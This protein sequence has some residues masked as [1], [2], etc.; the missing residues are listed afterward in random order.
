MRTLDGATETLRHTFAA[1][2]SVPSGS[3]VVVFGGGTEAF[4]PADPAFGCAQVVKASSGRL[5][6]L[7]SG[8]TIVVTDANGNLTA[9]LTYG[10]AGLNGGA[11]QS[12]TRSPDVTGDFTLHTTAPVP[13]A[14]PSRRGSELTARPSATAPRD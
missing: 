12:M 5:S 7:N 9:Q 10:D 8:E 13:T 4:D 14:A 2:T 11:N 3:A 1:G 6:L